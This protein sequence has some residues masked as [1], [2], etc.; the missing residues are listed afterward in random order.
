MTESNTPQV[1]ASG[2]LVLSSGAAIPKTDYVVKKAPNAVEV[3]SASYEYYISHNLSTA[4]K[5]LFDSV[6]CRP[7]TNLVHPIVQPMTLPSAHLRPLRLGG[8]SCQ[9]FDLPADLPTAS[10]SVDFGRLLQD[11]PPADGAGYHLALPERRWLAKRVASRRVCPGPSWLLLVRPKFVANTPILPRYLAFPDVGRSLWRRDNPTVDVEQWRDEYDFRLLA[12]KSVGCLDGRP[13]N[14]LA[15]LLELGVYLGSESDESWSDG[16]SGSINSR[17]SSSSHGSQPRH[18]DWLNFTWK[19]GGI[20]YPRTNGHLFESCTRQ[21]VCDTLLAYF[22]WHQPGQCSHA[23]MSL[24]RHVLYKEPYTGGSCFTRSHTRSSHSRTDPIDLRTVD[25][26][27]VK[28][29]EHVLPAPS[30]VALQRTVE[31]IGQ[32][33][34]VV[35][36]AGPNKPASELIPL[37]GATA[38]WR[39]INILAS[40]VG[41][42]DQLVAISLRRVGGKAFGHLKV[43]GTPL[44]RLGDLI[45]ASGIYPEQLT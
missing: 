19:T 15:P 27:L 21:Q 42:H 43:D 23:D 3:P 12:V 22:P 37:L 2:K 13:L 24:V 33:C 17:Y 11:L 1:V 14:D 7:S 28:V 20:F 40:Q 38:R 6:G 5:S 39:D 36:L 32:F 29:V 10:W 30:Q 45:K 26:L 35:P 18:P 25:V 8:P 41:A 9:P 34:W 44:H 16:S 31:A 4:F